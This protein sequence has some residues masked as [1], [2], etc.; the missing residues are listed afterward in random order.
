[1]MPKSFPLLTLACVQ[2]GMTAQRQKTL[3][4]KVSLVHRPRDLNWSEFSAFLTL[5]RNH[6]IR[7]LGGSK[8]VGL[9]GTILCTFSVCVGR[10]GHSV[11]LIFPLVSSEMREQSRS[12]QHGEIRLHFSFPLFRSAGQCP[13]RASR[14]F[15][16]RR[17][18]EA[19][20]MESILP[21]SC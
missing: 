14:K 1:M 7:D 20:A 12:G 6:K 11:W 21:P 18:K 2:Q 19:V 3:L 9:G 5:I 17:M 13:Y 8:V 10:A 4:F 16:L 15:F